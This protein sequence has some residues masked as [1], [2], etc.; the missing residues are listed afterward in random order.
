MK[1]ENNKLGKTSVGK[2]ILQLGLP[3]VLSMVLQAIYNVV[4]T[5]FVINSDAGT[6]GNAALTAAFPIQ[7]LMIAVGVGTGVGINALLSRKL[8]E[9]DFD[10][11]NKIA[12]NGIFLSLVI[13]A[14]FL[15]FGLFLAK[16]YMRLTS[17]D[18]TVVDMG[19]TYLRICC[20]LSF[21]SIGYTVYERFLQS[22]GKTTSSMIAQIAGAATNIVLDY[23]FVMVSHR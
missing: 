10:A 5:V 13:Y 11:V 16:P 4:E 20:C 3:M 23:V 21:G 7:I 15:L 14:V 6:Y 8:G 18:E 12:G 2:L 22:T 1:K 17:S 9:K 19:A